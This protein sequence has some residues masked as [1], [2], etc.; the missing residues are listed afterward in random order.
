MV[1]FRYLLIDRSV[2]SNNN[3]IVGG[4]TR[5]NYRKYFKQQKKQIKK[6]QKIINKK[7]WNIS[8]RLTRVES[9]FGRIKNMF[10]NIKEY[11]ER[12]IKSEELSNTFSEEIDQNQHKMTQMRE[13]SKDYNILQLKITETKELKNRQDKNTVY[14]TSKVQELTKLIKK[15]EYEIS[16]LKGN[17]IRILEQGMELRNTKSEND[18][19]YNY[20]KR[21][22]WR[23]TCNHGKWERSH[24]DKICG[25]CGGT[26]KD[27]L[28]VAQPTN[29][30][31]KKHS[32]GAIWCNDCNDWSRG[33]TKNGH[34]T[35]FRSTA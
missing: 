24:G 20:F 9:R 18:E 30:N 27:D 14:Y 10:P 13:G 8:K 5:S 4:A 28:A 3:I 17:K 12:I 15:N 22:E 16:K 2:G 25:K 26:F 29:V 23:E 32:S 6:K 34:E 1:Y 31:G 33:C 7:L 21:M 11:E 35:M 19:E